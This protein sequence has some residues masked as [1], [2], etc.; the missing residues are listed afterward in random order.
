MEG[1]F[2]KKGRG[3]VV[4]IGLG[5]LMAVPAIV[6]LLPGGIANGDKIAV[7]ILSCIFGILLL[8]FGIL[9]ATVN[10]GAY[11]YMEADHVAAK[12][13]WFANY[14]WQYS[15]ITSVNCGL[16]TLRITM[17]SGKMYTI[18]GLVNADLLCAQLRKKIRNPYDRNTLLEQWKKTGEQRKKML[19]LL[20]LGVI[21]VFGGIALCVALTGGRDLSDFTS[22]DWTIFGAF[23]VLEL[24]LFVGMFVIAGRVGKLGQ[25]HFSLR[26]DLERATLETAPLLPGKV[27]GVYMD[28]GY[29]ER[30][31]VFGYPDSEKVYFCVEKINEN[32]ELSCTYRSPLYDSIEEIELENLMQIQ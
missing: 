30:T 22:S 27:L 20:M 23:G 9:M 13:N 18:M 3:G 26:S 29:Q 7:S 21:D 12:F 19:A 6:R 4:V 2:Y 16:A 25:K 28:D 8:T 5:L 32:F 14:I 31:T 15:D 24:G 10:H 1:I 17:S 11:F